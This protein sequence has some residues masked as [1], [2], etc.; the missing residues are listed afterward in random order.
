MSISPFQLRL[1]VTLMLLPILKVYN[2]AL[3]Y[4]ILSLFLLDYLD[5]GIYNIFK[6]YKCKRGEEDVTNYQVRDKILDLISYVLFVFL[7]YKEF[8]EKTLNILIILII[9]RA[10]GVIKFSKSKNRGD[11]KLFFDGINGV[12]ILYLLSTKF[13][14]VK[15]NYNVLL[16]FTILIK[17]LFEQYHHRK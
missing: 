8:D 14:L 7:F 1:A 9:W 6:K 15:N 12:L 16:V 13:D 5:C 11:L 10:I 2:T 3:F 17:I 4:P